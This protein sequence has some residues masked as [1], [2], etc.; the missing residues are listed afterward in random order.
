MVKVVVSEDCGNSPK[1][2][3]LRDFNVAI[4]KGD[5]SVVEHTMS[6][7][8]VWNL[9]EPAGQAQIRG[10][11]NVLQEYRHNLVIV[12]VE[13]SIDT[14]ITHGNTGAVNGT[15]KARDKKSYVFCDIYKFSSHAKSTKIKEMTSYIIEKKQ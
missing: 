7:D 5:F 10:R 11:D 9:F 13:F 15:I 1:N 8:V 3:L 12:P 2:L 4:A 6:E 14:I